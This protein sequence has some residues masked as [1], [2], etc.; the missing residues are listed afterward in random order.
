[1]SILSTKKVSLF[2]N[3][4][5]LGAASVLSLQANASDGIG[6]GDSDSKWVVGMA[7]AAFTNPYSDESTET[8]ISPTI[9]YNGE[10]FFI[11]DDSI[12]LHLAK[13]HGFSV[14]LTAALDA[15]FL[16]DESFYKDNKKLMDLN[17]RDGTILGGA[18]IN[19]DSSLGR[20][21][22]R[23]LTDLADKHDGQAASL[24]YTFDLKAGNWNINP[25]LGVQWLS[26]DYVNHHV[27]IS[28]DESTASRYQYSGE[29]TTNTFAGIRARYDITENW[30]VNLQ[31]GVTKLGNGFSYSTIIDDDTVYQASVGINY[32]F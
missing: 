21:S 5:L 12:G 22:F 20:L 4:S 6:P 14:G 32:N 18:Y 31:T 27:G 17:K 13:S 3:L 24:K 29:N 7:V 19:H 23:A 10:R 30:D 25:V 16:I 11:N 8:F 28:T 1:M 2:I 9:R 26:S 15:G